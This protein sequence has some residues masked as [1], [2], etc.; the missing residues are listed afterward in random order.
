MN[1]G[2]VGRSASGEELWKLVVDNGAFYGYPS[3]L[4]IDPGGNT[5][6]GSFF[7]GLTVEGLDPIPF[8]DETSAMLLDLAP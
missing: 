8:T 4:A 5:V 2:F 3:S 7:Y 1:T 6:L